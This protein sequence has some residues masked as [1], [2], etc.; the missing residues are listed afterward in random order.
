MDSLLLLLHVADKA[1]NESS[2]KG[3]PVSAVD[4]ECSEDSKRL[5]MVEKE[6]LPHHAAYCQILL[7]SLRGMPMSSEA[8]KKCVLEGCKHKSKYLASTTLDPRDGFIT[9]AK[10]FHQ[11]EFVRCQY[12]RLK[13]G[14]LPVP[15]GIHMG[16]YLLP[17]MLFICDPRK[18]TSKC[19][20]P[21]CPRWGADRNIISGHYRETHSKTFSYCRLL[22]KE[23]EIRHIQIGVDVL[24]SQKND[25]KKRKY[26]YDNSP[27]ETVVKKEKRKELDVQSVL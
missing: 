20:I 7:A 22:T 15:E 24:L 23:H 1:D 14:E 8:S 4:V 18:Y 17:L 11:E 26:V 16:P 21:N 2:D 13:D 12:Q 10:N 27:V 6:E 25:K 9:H 19:M 3:N 5:D